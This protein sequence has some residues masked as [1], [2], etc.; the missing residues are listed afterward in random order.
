MAAARSVVR[1][2]ST[3]GPMLATLGPPPLGDRWSVEWKFDGQRAS[4]IVTGD[5]VI[6][7]SRNGSD[8]SGT[9]PELSAVGAAV[10]GR[11]VV[12]DG[13]IVA[14]DG[15]GRP[16]FTRLQRRWPQQRRPRAELL[17][18]VPV[19]LMAFDVLSVDGRDLTDEPLERR[20]EV[21]ES[22]VVEGSSV[23]TVPKAFVGVPAPDMLAVAEE[24]LM[25]GIV[26]KALDSPYREGRSPWWVKSPVRQTAELVVVAYAGPPGQVRALLLAGHN[27][28]GFLEVAGQVG[29]GFSAAMRRH[30]GGLLAPIERDSPSVA[31]D[32][33]AQGW[34]W[35]EPL[36][37]GEVAFREYAPGR[38]LRHA[39]WKGL[40]DAD[41]M[42]AALPT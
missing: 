10:G 42:T 30:L 39:S 2:R 17:R 33:G 29:T 19:R 32:V 14:L 7:F 41:P 38:G 11:S 34:R 6:V 26:A 9:F 3:P 31:N 20:R 13:E 24:H 36:Y 23:L 12:L 35:V 4:V 27:E 22:L 5:E 16:S 15:D 1:R 18:A 8:V 21:L 25:E 40:R 28:A 37:V